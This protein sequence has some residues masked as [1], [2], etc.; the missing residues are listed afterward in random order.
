MANTLDIN[1]ATA[2]RMFAHLYR[3]NV[4]LQGRRSDEVGVDWCKVHCQTD[5]RMSFSKERPPFPSMSW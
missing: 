2:S 1:H 3:E 4:L 5:A